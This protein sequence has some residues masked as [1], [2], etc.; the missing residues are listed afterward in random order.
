M[1]RRE[2]K[3]NQK[4]IDEIVKSEKEKWA[5]LKKHQ[6]EKKIRANRA[7]YDKFLV[8][9]PNQMRI[10][11]LGESCSGKTCLIKRFIKD[12][13]SPEYVTTTQ[14]EAFKSD[15]LFFE[16]T[17]YRIELIDTPP[18]ENFYKL[19][20]DV[21][22][23]VQGVVLVFDASNKNSFLRME[24]YFRMINF[25][26]FQKVG[27]IA[28]KKDICTEKDKYKYYQLQ[29]FCAQN[30]A[31]PYFLSSKNGKKD[32]SNFFDLLCP[33]IIPSL[34][35]KKEELKLMYPYTKSVKNNFPKKNI[36]DEAIIKKAKDDDSS[37]IS[38]NSIKVEKTKEEEIREFY[39]K[40]KKAPEKRRSKNKPNYIYN[41]GNNSKKKFQEDNESFNYEKKKEELKDFNN[42]IGEVNL[43]LEK[44]FEKY[45]PDSTSS[46]NGKNKKRKNNISK[47][48]KTIEPDRDWV[49][50]NIDSL[51]EEFL[52]TQK[53]F[54]K[55]KKNKEK[56]IINKNS[57]KKNQKESKEKSEISKK[58]DSKLSKSKE[59]EKIENDSKKDKNENKKESEDNKEDN[60]E[61]QKKIENRQ[62]ESDKK[63]DS[64]NDDK[65]KSEEEENENNSEESK[66]GNDDYEDLYGDIYEFQQNAM[67]EAMEAQDQMGE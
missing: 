45:R 17:S 19:L 50:I 62:T 22:Y 32:I 28:T 61:P 35:N 48:Y 47:K 12:E 55:D 9:E 3:I 64:K 11:I 1:E 4:K 65:N 66:E 14:I 57:N 16:D 31:I 13:F 25:Y 6:E 46:K 24:D 59:E 49:N 20:D 37:Y 2:A 27:I 42:V 51:V 5:A 18:L 41:I 33:E 63:K 58:S 7:Q 39:L 15:L 56:Q 36:I 40:K 8:Q 21:L 54:K 29:K 53:K 38:E 30:K 52:N 60:E 26:E 23:F 67:K 44:L 34:V 43:D 10:I